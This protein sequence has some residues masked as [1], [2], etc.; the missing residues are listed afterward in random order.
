MIWL[1]HTFLHDLLDLPTRIFSSCLIWLLS[2]MHIPHPVIDLS[3]GEM[4]GWPRNFISWVYILTKIVGF[5][6][7]CGGVQPPNTPINSNPAHIASFRQNNLIA[8]MSSSSAWLDGAEV[9]ASGWGSGGPRFQ[10]HPRLTF[11]SC[12]RY[13]LNQLGSKAASESTFKK[14]N[15]CG[16]SNTRLYSFF[17]IWRRNGR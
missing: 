3:L 10:S 11:Q 4:G 1:H 17:F 13:Q 16:V 6:G 5:E 14:S 2:S 15:T 8:W 9:S 7:W 12:S